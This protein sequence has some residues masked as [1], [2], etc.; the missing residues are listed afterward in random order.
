MFQI[1]QHLDRELK[2]IMVNV[3]KLLFEEVGIMHEQTENSSRDVLRRLSE[4]MSKSVFQEMMA[5]T[6]QI[7]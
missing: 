4:N 6:F 3:L 7:K 1:L 2:I 5:E